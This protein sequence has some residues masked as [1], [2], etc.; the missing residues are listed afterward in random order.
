MPKD[1]RREMPVEEVLAKKEE[2]IM[3]SVGHYYK[4]PMNLVKGEGNYLYDQKGKEYL[5]CFGGILT[6][7]T[8]HSLP[9]IIG[10]IKEQLERLQH[11]STVY[12]IQPMV[13]LAE[14]LSQLTQ[15]KLKKTFFV[16][17][18][19]EANEGALMLAK[20]YSGNND[21]IAL[22]HSY[23]GRSYVAQSIT[24]QASWRAG[25]DT[26]PGIAFTP[27]GYCYRCSY[28]MTYPGCDV[29]CAHQLREII[30]TQTS[31]HIAAIIAEPIQGVGGFVTPPREY[32]T[33]LHEIVKEHGGLF[34]SDEVQTALGR[35]GD[36]FFGITH[37]DVEPDIITMAKGVANG[38]PMGLYMA[39][40]EIADIYQ[41]PSISTF[42]GNHIS[43]TAALANLDLIEEENLIENTSR[44]GEY[45]FKGLEELQK[46]SMYIGDVRGR[47]LML[48]LEIVEDRESKAPSPEKTIEI[49]EVAKD[50]G[51]LIGKGGLFANTLRLA[52]PLRFQ[53]KDVDEAL[54]ILE[55][56][57]HE[58][59]K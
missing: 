14:K 26:L 3:P 44:V 35:T 33:I 47:G 11:T 52:P 6:V 1:W 23:H 49:M 27:N 10:P 43:T 57:F 48:G 32:F 12:L 53:E 28:N 4:E 17:S 51:L 54:E 50:H 46:R 59:E 25:K 37:W 29:H 39:R 58:V 41:G 45:F 2:Y 15:G 40:E 24:G 30:R 20:M 16:N 19:T 38:A 13:L 55:K 22:S 42:G 18:G 7:M 31:G 56:T 5:D 8:G 36:Y 21:I 9:Q 34:I